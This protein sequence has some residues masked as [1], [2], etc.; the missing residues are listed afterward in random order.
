M[1]SLYQTTDTQHSK[2]VSWELP[3]P[4]IAT[5]KN[6]HHGDHT[7]TDK[8]HHGLVAK[9]QTQ[10]Q[11]DGA[12]YIADI[13]LSGRNR[14]NEDHLNSCSPIF[15]WWLTRGPRQGSTLWCIPNSGDWHLL[16][17]VTPT[18]HRI[19]SKNLSYRWGLTWCFQEKNYPSHS[20]WSALTSDWQMRFNPDNKRGLV[21][22]TGGSKPSKSTDAGRGGYRW[23]SKR[24]TPTVLGAPHRDIPVWNICH[25]GLHNGE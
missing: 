8:W 18:N 15:M 20:W 13:I 19:W 4:H 24:G 17:L 6:L 22:Y 7:C 21:W 3:G 9:G 2:L 25:Q 12:H 10:C 1:G 5:S 14:G 16:N 11:Q 23:G